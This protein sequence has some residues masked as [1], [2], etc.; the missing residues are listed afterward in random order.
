[1]HKSYSKSGRH[2]AKSDDPDSDNT[3]QLTNF[4]EKLQTNQGHIANTQS[5]RGLPKLKTGWYYTQRSRIS[6]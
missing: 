3:I 1:M 6:C 4:A 2:Y 5:T